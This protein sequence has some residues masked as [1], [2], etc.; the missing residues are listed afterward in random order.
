ML[1]IFIKFFLDLYRFQLRCFLVIHLPSGGARRRIH[2]KFLVLPLLAWIEKT[3]T[4]KKLM[5]LLYSH[6][7]WKVHIYSG[8]YRHFS[9]VHNLA[10]IDDQPTLTPA[11][12]WSSREFQ[13]CS[14]PNRACWARVPL[15]KLAIARIQRP[16][17]TKKMKLGLAPG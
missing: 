8:K 3:T 7:Q 13:C 4:E 15:K 9:F 6:L 16:N 2:T 10:F 11:R 12:Y 1:L 17:E 14:E 5:N